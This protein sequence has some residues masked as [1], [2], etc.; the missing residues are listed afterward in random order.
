MKTT[1]KKNKLANDKESYDISMSFLNELKKKL[2][3]EKN[4]E[5]IKVLKRD[6]LKLKNDCTKY[7]TK[8]TGDNIKILTIKGKIQKYAKDILS[9]NIKFSDID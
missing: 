9:K 5:N 8:L 1:S 7:K 3:I 6:I 4:F 2:S